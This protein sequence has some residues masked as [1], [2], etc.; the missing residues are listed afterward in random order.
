MIRSSPRSSALLFVL[1]AIMIP[2]PLTAAEESVSGRWKVVVTQG[3]S[4][5]D[6][7]LELKQDGEKVTG[8]L[9]S[10]RS[11]KS[12][13]EVGSLKDKKLRVEVP[14]KMGENT[15]LFVVEATFTG[16]GKLEGKLIVDGTESGTVVVTREGSPLAGKWN[17]T[18]KT[19][20]GEEFTSTLEISSEGDALKGKVTGRFGSLDLKEMKFDGEKLAAELVMPVDGNETAFVV[21]AT[22]K[23]ANTLAGTWKVKDADFSG[24]WTATREAAAA[25]RKPIAKEVA[26]RWFGVTDV[27]GQGKIAF[28]IEIKLDGENVAARFGIGGFSADIGQISA[29]GTRFSATFQYQMGGMT[30]EVKAVGEL[31]DSVLSGKWTAQS[32]ETGEWSAQKPARM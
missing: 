23:D 32:G 1:A 30:A 9:V 13:F 27:P 11:G 8:A 21:T 16:S 19:P 10:P 5:K 17:V 4:K 26:G 2:A 18:T 20:Q 6:Y 25:A 7:Y 3:E 14:R 12:P 31:K 28:S 29:E 22:L 15:V 24:E